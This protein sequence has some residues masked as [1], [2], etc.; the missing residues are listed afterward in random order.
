MCVC[1]YRV[2]VHLGRMGISLDGAEG[3]AGIQLGQSL[4]VRTGFG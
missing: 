1:A 4:D 3:G 2:E